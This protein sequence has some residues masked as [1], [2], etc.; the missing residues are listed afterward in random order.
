MPADDSPASQAQ[1]DKRA[2]EDR[3][4]LRAAEKLMV[5]LLDGDHPV[6]VRKA[7]YDWLAAQAAREDGRT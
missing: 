2:A 3:A 7:V 4:H 5:K 1:A 6:K